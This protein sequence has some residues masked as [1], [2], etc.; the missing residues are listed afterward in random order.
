[1]YRYLGSMKLPNVMYKFK[2]ITEDVST[3]TTQST[4]I[5]K[6]MSVIDFK[7][8]VNFKKGTKEI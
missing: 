6:I 1:M 7:K 8:G 2:G 5:T 4:M 3:V